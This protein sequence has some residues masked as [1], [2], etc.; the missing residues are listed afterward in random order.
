MRLA[1]LEIIDIGQVNPRISSLLMYFV[2]SWDTNFAKSL[3][4]D[5]IGSSFICVICGI[6]VST[7]CG[8]PF[9]H[10]KGVRRLSNMLHGLLKMLHVT[11]LIA[12]VT[13]VQ[14]SFVHIAYLCRRKRPR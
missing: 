3:G 8:S 14:A 1:L 2:L 11:K 12:F 7:G 9:R 5:D 4:A 13:F 6:Y 10:K